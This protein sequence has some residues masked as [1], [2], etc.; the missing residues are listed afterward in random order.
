MCGRNIP[1]AVTF[2]S[3]KT[4][5]TR[6]SLSRA[7]SLP[8]DPCTLLV[9][10]KMKQYLA[11]HFNRFGARGF[12]AMSA[13]WSSRGRC[14]IITGN[15]ANTRKFTSPDFLKCLIERLCAITQARI[16]ALLFMYPSSKTGCILVMS[17]TLAGLNKFL[18][19]ANHCTASASGDD[20]WQR[21]SCWIPNQE[22]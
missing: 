11:C 18:A 16:K 3:T 22:A 19:H 7:V 1:V 17:T 4:K 10:V 15:C 5:F 9:T 21:S 20:V 6:C 2:Q 13:S 8:I 12:V 14:A